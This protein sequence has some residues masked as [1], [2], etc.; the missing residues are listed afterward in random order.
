[1]T[2]DAALERRMYRSLLLVRR[3]EERIAALYGKQ[4]MRCPTHLC[5]GQEAVAAGVC[6]AIEPTDALF[7]TY[8]SHGLYL[9]QGGDPKAMLAEIYGKVTGVTK[10]RGG[11]MQLIA[12]EVGLLCTSALVGGTI[13]LAAGA[14]LAAKMRRTDRVAVAVFGDAATEE[15]V[16]HEALNFAALKRLPVIFVCEHNYFAVYTHQRDRQAADNIPD[17]VRPYGIPASRHDG[18]DVRAVFDAT[19][20]AVARARAGGGPS[21]LEFRTYRWLEHVGPNED[22]HLGYRPQAEID[23]WRARCPIRRH[24]E[25]LEREGILGPGEA[26]RLEAEVGRIV[27]EAVAFARSSPFPDPATATEGVYAA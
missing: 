26:D 22:G 10:G 16:F 25:A 4:E 21:F 9:A 6:A 5:I 1:M 3:M 20:D 8:R 17:R 11:S 18:N 27:D 7:G 15:G 2:R 23:E 12:P 24:R 14:A 19:A 13:P